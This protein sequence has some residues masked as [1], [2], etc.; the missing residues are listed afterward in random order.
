MAQLRFINL[1]FGYGLCANR[2]VMIL[3]ARTKQGIAI[4]NKAREEGKW[5]NCTAR[6]PMST[7]LVLDDGHVVGCAFLSK[8]LLKRLRNATED[9]AP[10]TVSDRFQGVAG[11]DLD[12]EDVS[13][14]EISKIEAEDEAEDEEVNIDDDDSED[15]NEPDRCSPDDM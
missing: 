7:I 6:R 11:D 3:K 1:G 8:T 13:E 2:V 9:D 15:E 14:A 12:E 5:I 10:I 4:R